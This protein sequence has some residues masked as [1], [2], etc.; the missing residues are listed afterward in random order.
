MSPD[1]RPSIPPALRIFSSEQ[2]D[3]FSE[4]RDRFQR[5]AT[6][7]IINQDTIS[8][9][10]HVY[11]EFEAAI[12]E[13]KGLHKVPHPN[14]QELLRCLR[15]GSIASRTAVSLAREKFRLATIEVRDGKPGVLLA[16]LDEKALANALGFCAAMDTTADR[17]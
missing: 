8:R 12:G 16:G 17:I 15:G 1:V 5:L 4:I 10:W 3:L 11:A 2:R 7:G 13:A 14:T 6:G 9:G